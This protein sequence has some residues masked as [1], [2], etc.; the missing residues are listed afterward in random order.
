MGAA[1]RDAAAINKAVQSRPSAVLWT[2]A[3]RNWQP[4]LPKLREQGITVVSLGNYEPDA[5]QGP[6][7]WLKCV[8]AGVVAEVSPGTG[9]VVVYL[10][11]VS[12][13]DLRAIESCPRE[14]QPLAELQYRGVFWSQANAKDWSINAFLTSRNGGLGLDVAQ[15]RATQ[16][17]LIRALKA[18]VLLE[19]P[20]EELRG[21]QINAHWLDALLAPNFWALS[22]RLSRRA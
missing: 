20:V 4:A 6:A 9:P 13:A 16:D 7:I 8:V 15:D 19:R 3:D 5:F 14:L 12:R 21:R 10:P 11:G 22:C 18:G 1:L 2:D 17:A